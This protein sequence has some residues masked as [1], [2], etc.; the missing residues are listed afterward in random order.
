MSDEKKPATEATAETPATQDPAE[1]T[2]ENAAS[3]EPP[4]TPHGHLPPATLTLLLTSVGTQAL[5]SLGQIPH[6]ATNKPEI[7]REQA[8][9]CIDLLGMLEEKTANNRTTEE[10]QMLDGMLYELRMLFLQSGK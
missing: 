7:D 2:T 1:A 6:P 8:Q 3:S 5:M 4:Q 10:S 9:H